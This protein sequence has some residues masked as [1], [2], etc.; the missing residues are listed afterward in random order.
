LEVLH[1]YA[2][3][4]VMTELLKGTKQAMEWPVASCGEVD[5]LKQYLHDVGI[6]SVAKIPSGSLYFHAETWNDKAG[7]WQGRSACKN[8][9]QWFEKIGAQ[10][11]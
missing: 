1:Q 4:T 11:V 6:T 7:K 2:S 5:A 3:H 10:R 9:S 8:C